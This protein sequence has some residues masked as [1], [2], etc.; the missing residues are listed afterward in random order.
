MLISHKDI[1]LIKIPTCQ[2]LTTYFML[3][4][5]NSILSLTTNDTCIFSIRARAFVYIPVDKSEHLSITPTCRV[6]W[7]LNNDKRF[8]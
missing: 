7:I 5:I 8:Y 1:L 3:I 6:Q 2:N 4:S